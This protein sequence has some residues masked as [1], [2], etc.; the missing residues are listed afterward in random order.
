MAVQS[1]SA[2]VGSTSNGRWLKCSWSMYS[3]G[4]FIAS[5]DRRGV[6]ALTLPPPPYFL[7]HSLFFCLSSFVQYVWW[8]MLSSPLCL[9]TPLFSI[10]KTQYHF[11]YLPF[12]PWISPQGPL[13]GCSGALNYTHCEIACLNIRVFKPTGGGKKVLKGV[14]C[15]TSWLSGLIS[16]SWNIDAMGFPGRSVFDEPGVRLSIFESNCP[17]KVLG[18]QIENRA[19]TATWHELKVSH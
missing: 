4:V 3:W 11:F 15:N 19:S 18:K 14:M 16:R 13:S 6:E 17:F 8:F 1:E 7:C 12:N 10:V 2:A 5:I 9:L